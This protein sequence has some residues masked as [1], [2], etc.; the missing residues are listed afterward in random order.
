M[1]RIQ[2]MRRVK[3]S[4]LEVGDVIE[5]FWK[6]YRDTITGFRSLRH[7]TPGYSRAADFATG[8]GMTVPDNDYFQVVNR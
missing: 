2:G 5:V 8:P 3:G 7:A 4:E 6:P 1:R